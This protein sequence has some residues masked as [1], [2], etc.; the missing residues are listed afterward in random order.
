MNVLSICSGIGGLDLFTRNQG[1]RTVCYVEKD[2]YRQA[3]LQARMRDGWLDS[4]PIWPDLRTFDGL[5][6]RGAVDCIVGGF[7]CQPFS[8][9]GRQR[10]VDDRRNLWPWVGSTIDSARPSLVFLENAPGSLHFFHHHVVP[11]LQD[12]GY[13]VAPPVLAAAAELGAGHIRRRVFLLAYTS[14]INLRIE[15]G[16]RGGQDRQ[17][18]SV[19]SAA[20]YQGLPADAPTT[21][22]SKRR[23]AA[24][25]PPRDTTRGSQPERLDWWAAEPDVARVVH[26]LPHRMDRVGALG[27]AVVNQQA[28]LAWNL[29]TGGAGYSQGRPE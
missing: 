9:A 7:P 26:G 2:E 3:V 4:A 6:W 29:L 5:A 16:W 12:L 17:G 28:G 13:H 27:D 8:V 19:A 1:W 23:Q 18:T 10:G 24:Y 15:P 11:D 20:S 25:G 22:P 14:E 21:R